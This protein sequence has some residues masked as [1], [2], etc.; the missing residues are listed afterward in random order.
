MPEL[1][2]I[3][4]ISAALPAPIHSNKAII[5]IQCNEMYKQM[6]SNVIVERENTKQSIGDFVKEHLFK[7]LKF[8]NLELLIYDTKK[9]NICQKVC[10]H[11]NMAEE[12]RITFW[13]TYSLCVENAMK[14]RQEF[15]PKTKELE[16]ILAL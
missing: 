6:S 11:L 7:R 12:G 8:Y 1:A 14:F 2:S 15:N 16:T 5:P 13:S 9:S 4:S 3:S 10:N